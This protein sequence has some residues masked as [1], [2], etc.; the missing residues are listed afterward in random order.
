LILLTLL[1]APAHADDYLARTYSDPTGK[2]MPYRLLIPPAYVA[3]QKYPLVLFF[4]GAGERATDNKKQLALV[5]PLFAAAEFQAAHPCFVV[6]PQCPP[7]R[8]W[9]DMPWGALSGVRPPQPSQSMQLA[10]GIL[11]QVE[12]QFNIDHDRVYVAGLSMGGYAVWDCVTRFPDRFAAGVACCGGGDENTVTAAVARVP[13]WAFHSADDTVVPV[14]R[15]RNMIA[16]MKKMGGNPKYTEFQGLGHAS[17]DKAYSEPGLYDW[18][19]A[20]RLSK[21]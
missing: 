8:Q 4:H 19:F 21:R 20:Q 5:A 18:L 7:D 1:P 14:V 17:W 9:V 6:A 11:E 16:A 10:L 15:S 2:S 3:G 13:V 12:S